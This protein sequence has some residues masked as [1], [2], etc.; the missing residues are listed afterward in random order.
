MEDAATLQQLLLLL[1]FRATLADDLNGA[2]RYDRKIINH[3]PTAQQAL[4]FQSVSH[5]RCVLF[6]WHIKGD[7]ILFFFFTII[8]SYCWLFLKWKERGSKAHN[9]LH[10]SVQTNTYSE[11]PWLRLAWLIRLFTGLH[12]FCV[13]SYLGLALTSKISLFARRDCRFLLI[14]LISKELVMGKMQKEQVREEAHVQKTNKMG[15]GN[16]RGCC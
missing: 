1:G 15:G 9:V 12:L 11:W 10:H 2:S 3:E 14:G 4:H 16:G 5:R 7:V 6:L 8:N 13:P